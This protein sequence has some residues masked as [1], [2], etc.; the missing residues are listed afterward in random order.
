MGEVTYVVSKTNI[1]GDNN[2]EQYISN[3][4]VKLSKNY[5]FKS[6]CKCSC[7]SQNLHLKTVTKESNMKTVTKESNIGNNKASQQ[8]YKI[9]TPREINEKIEF[10]Y[11][12]I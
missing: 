10:G 6:T 8:K 11:L 7:S 2:R 9:Y 3:T 12:M 4:C 1:Y 5:N